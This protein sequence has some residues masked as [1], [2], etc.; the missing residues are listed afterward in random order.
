MRLTNASDRSHVT[1]AVP[2][3][4]DGLFAMLPVL[5][6]G[7]V[8]IA[9]EGVRLPLRALIAPPAKNRRP[10]SEDPKAIAPSLGPKNR[11]LMGGWDQHRP[12]EDYGVVVEVWR[13]QSPQLRT[14]THD[15]DVENTNPDEE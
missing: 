3:Y 14:S 2:D 11:K 1:G 15:I 7:E 4:L 9:G 12:P 10:D 6:T 8:I 13:G 5:R